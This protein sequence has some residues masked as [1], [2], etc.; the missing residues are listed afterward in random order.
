MKAEIEGYLIYWTT[1]DTEK[2]LD[3]QQ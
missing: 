2:T 1:S 3:V